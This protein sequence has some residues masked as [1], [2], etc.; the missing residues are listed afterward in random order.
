MEP[1]ADPSADLSDGESDSCII[2]ELDTEDV[3]ES[4]LEFT[5]ESIHGAKLDSE[6]ITDDSE[7]RSEKLK[8]KS[9]KT[10]KVQKAAPGF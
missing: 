8:S 9:P 10:H 1:N 6:V 2:K 5:S 3:S 4:E 7:K